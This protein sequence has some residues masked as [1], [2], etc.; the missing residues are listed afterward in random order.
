[1]SETRQ[2][3]HDPRHTVQEQLGPVQ[4]RI[5]LSNSLKLDTFLRL[6]GRPFHTLAASNRKDF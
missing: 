3:H 2:A 5:S 6:F 1:M 4:V